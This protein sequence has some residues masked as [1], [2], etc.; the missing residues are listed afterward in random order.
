MG[1]KEGG[2]FSESDIDRMKEELN[3]LRTAH[4]NKQHLLDLY[5][6]QVLPGHGPEESLSDQAARL[7]R[8]NEEME[9]ML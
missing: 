6:A 1:K 3:Q 7:D 4:V 5:Q 8:K 2:L 9:T